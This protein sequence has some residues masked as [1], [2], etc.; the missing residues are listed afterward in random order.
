MKTFIKKVIGFIKCKMSSITSGH[1]VYVGFNVKIYNKGCISLGN[2][3]IVRPG[4]GLYANPNCTLVIDDYAEIGRDSTIAAHSNIKIEKGVLTGPHIF[5]ADHNHEYRNVD[6][7]IYQQGANVPKDSS[8]I[9]GEG[10]W[11]GTNCVVVGNVHIGK[12][13]VI[14]ANSVVTKDIPDYSVAVGIPAKV[15][16]RYNFETMLWERVK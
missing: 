16:K 3:V 2:N 4:C 1:G 9:V 6:L 11:L 12:H 10:S 13:C 15:I 5:I 8:V 7:P 14:G